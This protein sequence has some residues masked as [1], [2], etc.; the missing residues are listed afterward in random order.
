[1]NLE[2]VVCPCAGTTKK[3]IVEAITDQKLTTVDE[4]CEATPAGSFC[5]SC[6]DDIQIVLDEQLG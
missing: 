6:R 5:G 1:M 4:I 3:E 2:D